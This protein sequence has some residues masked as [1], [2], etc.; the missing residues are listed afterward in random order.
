MRARIIREIPENNGA[1]ASKIK[2]C[3]MAKTNIPADVAI[4]EGNV[5]IFNLLHQRNGK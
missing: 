3:T 2:A 1:R 4:S 5:I